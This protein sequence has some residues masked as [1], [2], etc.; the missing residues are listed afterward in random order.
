MPDVERRDSGLVV[1]RAPSLLKHR[2]RSR[3]VT[4]PNG[5]RALVTMDDS[6]TVTQ[7][8]TAERLDAIV[9]PK[10]VTIQIRRGGA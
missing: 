4:L 10:T 1:P 3:T 8:E 5:K 2:P 6:G 9:R 7:I